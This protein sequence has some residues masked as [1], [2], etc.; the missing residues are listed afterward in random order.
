MVTEE[1]EFERLSQHGHIALRRYPPLIVAETLLDGDR[2]AASGKGFRAIADCIFEN[3][4]SS[5][6]TAKQGVGDDFHDCACSPAAL[7]K[8]RTGQPGTTSHARRQ[9][10]AG[11]FCSA[12]R[13]HIEHP[14]QA[15]QSSRAVREVPAKT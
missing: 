5:G 14:A 11:A 15:H 8:F 1:P 2:N 6:S 9:S 13:M 4:V 10:M 3:N 7:A 12:Q